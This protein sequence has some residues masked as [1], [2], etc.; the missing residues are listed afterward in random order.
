[1]IDDPFICDQSFP[2]LCSSLTKNGVVCS[3]DVE[4]D[5]ANQFAIMT[6]LHNSSDLHD[7]VMDHSQVLKARI[8]SKSLDNI[9]EAEELRDWTED[10]IDLAQ[11]YI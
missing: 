6:R 10:L 2:N 7:F 8:S 5:Q 11:Q 4:A 3:N 1:V 9:L